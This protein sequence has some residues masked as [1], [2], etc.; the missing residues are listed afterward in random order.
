MLATCGVLLLSLIG[1]AVPTV[2]IIYMGLYTFSNPDKEAWVGID[3]KGKQMLYPD[4]ETGTKAR[5]S[6]LV[7]IH[8]NFFIWFLWGFI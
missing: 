3:T 5:A 4:Q 2:Y 6:E 8:K 7:D 1:F